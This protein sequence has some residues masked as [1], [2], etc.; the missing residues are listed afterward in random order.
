MLLDSLL[1]F[2]A[3]GSP[4][5]LVAGAGVSIPSPG[6]IDLLGLG[7]G[8]A[9]DERIIGTVSTF[10]ADTG[11]GDH[12]LQVRVAIG[13]GLV[14]VGGSTLNV[15]F[16][17]APD[18]GAAGNYQPGTWQTLIETGAMTAAQLAANAICARFDWPPVFPVTL[19]PRFLRLLFAPSAGGSFSA[20]TIANAIVTNVRDDWYSEGNA[21]KNFSVGAV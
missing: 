3:Q 13:T 19:R 10:G 9:P 7:V 14:A 21:A 11:I 4:L 12:K 17:A 8:V 20:G 6:V 15:A 2:V 5:S 18:Q 1:G 16:Q